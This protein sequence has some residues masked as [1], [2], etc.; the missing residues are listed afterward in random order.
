MGGIFPRF[1]GSCDRWLEALPLDGCDLVCEPFAGSA[2]LTVHAHQNG[3]A[4]AISGETDPSVRVCLALYRIPPLFPVFRRAMI[5]HQ[6]SIRKDPVAAWDIIKQ[7]METLIAGGSR[8]SISELAAVSHAYRA[9]AYAGIVRSA[10]STNKLNV[11]MGKEQLKT[12]PTKDFSNLKIM[13]DGCSLDVHSDWRG[14]IA[15]IP[16]NA[17]AFVLID[18]PY[19]CGPKK[20]MEPC[21]P[22]HRPR[23]PETLGLCIDALSAALAHKGVRRVVMKNYATPELEQ[24][25]ESTPTSWIVIRK[26]TGQRLVG[27]GRRGGKHDL[28]V[29]NIENFWYFYPD[30]KRLKSQGKPLDPEFLQLQK[31]AAAAPS[32]GWIETGKVTGRNFKQAWWRGQ[33]EGKT[34][35]YIGRVGSAAYWDARSA[36]LARKKLKSYRSV[37]GH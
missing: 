33:Y 8:G 5:C 2:S 11:G 18:P 13:P 9:L 20:R 4:H 21:Y 31:I 19:Y 17:N 28:G 35:I 16:E 1:P 15:A 29:P 3:I 12:F 10:K 37:G 32:K 30:P 26:V 34:T 24:F 22:G 7:E 36:Q 14:A 23:D 6:A 25:L 27:P